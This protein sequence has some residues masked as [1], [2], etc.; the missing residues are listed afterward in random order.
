MIIE[1]EKSN[2][3]TIGAI[4]VSENNINGEFE[5]EKIVGDVSIADIDYDDIFDTNDKK[6]RLQ[7]ND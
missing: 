2:G 4:K 7:L 3:E 1:I 6:L 5:V